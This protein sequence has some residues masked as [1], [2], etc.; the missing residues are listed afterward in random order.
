MIRPQHTPA[1]FRRYMQMSTNRLF[2]FMEGKNIDPFFYS[3]L[4]KPTCRAAG[5]PCD[6]V[7]ADFV[8]GSGG[9]KTLI[10]LERYLQ[11]S[12]YLVLQVGQTRKS[13]IFYVDKDLDDVTRQLIK[14]PHIVYTPF[15]SVEN[16]LFIHGD[17]VIAA[18]AA[19]CV[20]SDVIRARIPDPN[21]WRRQNAERWKE[22]LILCLLSHKLGLN[23]ECHY[24]G[25]TSP[26]N[27]PAEAPTDAA[28]SAAIK[29]DLQTRAGLSAEKFTFKFRSQARY[30]DRIFQ[31]GLHDKLF[32]GKWYIEFLR[33]EIVLAAGGIGYHNPSNN[34]LTAT[35]NLT[36][37]FDAE[38]A[39]HFRQPLSL[40]ISSFG[41]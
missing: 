41:L 17:I 9:K 13:C 14:S 29:S 23:C 1:A 24:G 40:L 11:S 15:Y 12:G 26:L 30:V 19:S 22:F 4:L 37:N 25:M 27:V 5:I 8:T 7:R 10:E 39:S 35:L 31:K 28:R 18:A 33:R 6:F 21:L 2:I 20:D 38:W 34:T 32:N 36:L 16:T 3:S